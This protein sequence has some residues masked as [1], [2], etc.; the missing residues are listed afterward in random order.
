VRGATLRDQKLCLELLAVGKINPI[1]DRVYPL[2]EAAEAH[3]YLEG[4]R[5]IG[6]V[7]LLP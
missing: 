1:I 3:S 7:L 4:Q 2:A 6:K 5:Q